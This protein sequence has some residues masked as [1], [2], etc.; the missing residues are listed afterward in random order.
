M[1]KAHIPAHFWPEAVVTATYL[2]NRLPTKSLHFKT[3]LETL[4]THTTIPSSHSLPP[5]V[6][7]CVVYHL[8]NKLGTNLNLVP[9][10]VFLLGMG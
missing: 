9:L 6:F 2:T 8:P 10:N 4:Q 3:P 1:F 7:G 5:R